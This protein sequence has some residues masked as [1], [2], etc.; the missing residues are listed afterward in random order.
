MTP[1]V[2]ADEPDLL[3]SPIERTALNRFFVIGGPL[4]LLVGIV[5]SLWVHQQH[6]THGLVV[7]TDAPWVPGQPRAVRLQITSEA[8][9]PVGEVSAEAWLRRDGSEVALGPLVSVGDGGLA[10]ATFVV[11]ALP[12][13]PA[14]LR[15]RVEAG[16]VA[17]F[18]ELVDLD[19]LSAR[20]PTSG[21]AVVSS[22][23]SQYAD[24]SDPQPETHRIV[25]RPDGRLLASFD[26][27]LFVRATDPEGVPWVGPVEVRLADGE[28][29]E[30]VGDPD[31]PRLLHSGRTDA[32]GLVSI[33]GPLT[34]EVVRLEVRLLDEDDPTK[35]VA[36]RRVR[37]VSFAGAV[38]AN[39][40]PRVVEPGGTVEVHA[41]GLSAKRPVFVD[42]H[43]PDGAWIDTFTPPPLGREPPRPLAMPDLGP[44][45][46]Q[47]EAYHFTNDPGESTAVARVEVGASGLPAD[48]GALVQRQKDEL[49]TKRL[50]SG[51]DAELERKWLEHVA[52]AEL[53]DASRALA[54]R[55]LVGTLP[56]R[57]L[58]PPL[59][60]TTRDRDREA[61]ARW[62]ARWILGLRVYLLG[63][64]GAFLLA[65]TLVML[66]SHG[67]GAETTLLE[68][69]DHEEGIDREALIAHLRRARR[70]ALVRSFGVLAVMAGTLVAT[71]LLL[72]NLLW[73]V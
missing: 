41:F 5:L 34:S 23:M 32:L 57:V 20:T 1:S 73:E 33:A 68:L 67:R 7:Q 49:A 31:G 45:L 6:V 22:S 28:L 61:L 38:V 11:P 17:S 2:D 50:E 46:Y 25:V 13:G 8:G 12:S 36:K 42:L 35:I 16:E 14:Q 15:V 18:D 4:G 37:L 52:K 43:G 26:V 40:E 55:V 9:A 48:L 51:F 21:E 27:E 47:L 44:G 72:E 58:S 64:G 29:M 71:V 24:D 53:D 69:Q 66:R 65:M 3:T 56:P 39:V 70:D 19:L 10:Q 30:K 54:Q 59:A 62:K 60:L 63:G